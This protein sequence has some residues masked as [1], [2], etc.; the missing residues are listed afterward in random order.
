MSPNKL[1][2]SRTRHY[3]P[4]WLIHPRM[5]RDEELKMPEDCLKEIKTTHYPTHD[6]LTAEGS[7]NLSTIIHYE[8]YDNLLRLL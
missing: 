2:G 4:D 6:L 3:G 1:A 5:S 7:N 8:N